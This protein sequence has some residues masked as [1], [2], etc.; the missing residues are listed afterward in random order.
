MRDFEMPVFDFSHMQYS[1]VQGPMAEVVGFQRS[2]SEGEG[3]GLVED[4]IFDDNDLN[5]SINLPTRQDD[6]R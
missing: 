5:A 3:E 2:L 1:G 6:S 4:T